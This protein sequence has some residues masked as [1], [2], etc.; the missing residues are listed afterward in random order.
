MKILWIT[1]DD[2]SASAFEEHHTV[3]EIA[4]QLTVGA[5]TRSFEKEEYYFEAKLLEFGDVDPK[6]IEF[7]H[8]KVQDHDQKKDCNFYVVD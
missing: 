2:F 3:E 5:G 6:F 1:G 7:V 8:E 4:S